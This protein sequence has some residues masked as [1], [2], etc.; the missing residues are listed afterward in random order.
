MV[1]TS[2]LGAKKI[3]M[4]GALSAHPFPFSELPLFSRANEE[5]VYGKYTS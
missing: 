2:A 1:P 3:Q 5:E 4:L